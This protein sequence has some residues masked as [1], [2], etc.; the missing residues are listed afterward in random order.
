[1]VLAPVEVAEVFGAER[2]PLSSIL[3]LKKSSILQDLIS[4]RRAFSNK[5]VHSSISDS[6]I[7]KVD[8]SSPSVI[9]KRSFDSCKMISSASSRA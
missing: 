3:Y 6:V 4:K 9:A 7:V 2:L 8:I 5:V 1:M